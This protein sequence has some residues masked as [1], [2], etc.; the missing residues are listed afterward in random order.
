MRVT[1][2]LCLLGL[3]VDFPVLAQAPGDTGFTRA[4]AYIEAAADEHRREEGTPGIVVAVVTRDSLLGV[5]AVGVADLTT[6]VPLRPDGRFLA[7]S[8]SKSFTAVA[9]LQLQEEGLVEVHNP[10]QNYLPWFRM[11]APHGPITLDALLTHTAGLP[12]DRSDIPSSP[13]TALALR[14]RSPGVAPGQRFAYS[15]IGYQLLSLLIEEV[16]GLPFTESIRNR[17]IRPLGLTGT[18]PAVTQGGQLTAVTGYQYLWDDRPP[19][20]SEPLVPVTWSEYSAGDANIVTTAPDL[21]VFLR[22]LLNQGVGPSGRLLLPKSFARMV[23]RTVRAPELGSDMFYGY[24]LVLGSLE[25]DPVLWHSGGMPGYRSM[26]LGDMDEGV[27]VVVLMNGPG[28]PR[29][30]A[31]Y[32]LRVLIAVRQ[33]GRLPPVQVAL[34]PTEVPDAESY[35]GSF[36]DSAGHHLALERDGD[37]LF[38]RAEG[39]R[40]PLLRAEPGQFIAEDSTWRLF[41]LQVVR[42]RGRATEVMHGGRWFVS[43]DY[44]GPRQFPFPLA[45]RGFVGHYRAQVPYFSNYR[46]VL[47][48]GELLL[49]SPEGIEEP[50]VERG[51]SE[52]DVGRVDPAIERVRFADVVSGRALRMNLSGTD[53]Y[54]T[55]TP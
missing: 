50:L 10:I 41:P 8:I 39:E 34:P 48:K 31:E 13:Y 20:P 7:G 4:L 17:V 42:E 37:R 55:T 26:M 19:I 29:R 32:A 43:E 45:W 12:R 36:T 24:G 54:R 40:V 6:K 38:L 47:R 23:Q 46:V 1:L 30:L 51:G 33:K 16:E 3:L 53:Y 11:P 35:V 44:H 9:L 21:A 27:G 5:R 25:G 2:S 49:I 14:E 15:N 18:E 22:T 52:F 28:N